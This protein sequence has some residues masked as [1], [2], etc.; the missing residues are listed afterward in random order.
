MV[1]S[2]SRQLRRFY[3]LRSAD[4][5]GR[6]RNGHY[7]DDKG[8]RHSMRF[9]YNTPPVSGAPRDVCVPKFSL[10]EELTS[11]TNAFPA[12]KLPESVG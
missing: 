9:V 1:F 2:G 4:R 7:P 3:A 10:H 5:K 11:L 6:K 12:S 8:P